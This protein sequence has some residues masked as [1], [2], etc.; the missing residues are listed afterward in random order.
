LRASASAGIVGL[1]QHLRHA[2]DRLRM[3]GRLRDQFHRR[4]LA[5]PRAP[6]FA[7]RDDHVLRDAQVGRRKKQHAVLRVELPD[8][9]LL[10]SRSHFHDRALRTAARVGTRD[11][12]HGAIAVQQLAHF[13]GRQVDAGPLVVRPQETMAVG[14]AFDAPRHERPRGAPVLADRRAPARQPPST[15]GSHRLTAGK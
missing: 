3:P 14:V 15:L 7:W 4:D 1:A 2:A 9:A 10:A 13:R 5:R 11:A 6:L 8:D 12:H